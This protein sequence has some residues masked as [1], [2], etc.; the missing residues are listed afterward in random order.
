MCRVARQEAGLQINELQGRVSELKGELS[1]QYSVDN[2]HSSEK[3][4]LNKH[5]DSLSEGLVKYQRKLDAVEADNR[6]L[7]QV[8]IL[9]IYV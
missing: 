2:R 1:A 8:W 4:S 6:R 3:S 5:V 9:Y 7:M